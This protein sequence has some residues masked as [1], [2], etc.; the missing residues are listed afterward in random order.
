MNK[1]YY[2]PSE[3]VIVT[4]IIVSLL[5][6]NVIAFQ[7]MPKIN[8]FVKHR[9]TMFND[10]ILLSFNLKLDITGDKSIAKIVST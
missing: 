9:L 1:V 3:N 6:N 5:H 4:H 10:V 7:F 8:K 2:H